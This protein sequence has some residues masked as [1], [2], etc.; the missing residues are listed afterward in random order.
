MNWNKAIRTSHRW[1]S[2]G[3]TL[4]VA[5][6]FALLGAGQQPEQWVYYLP[7]P[8]LALMLVTGLYLFVL[9]YLSRRVGSGGI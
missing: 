2:I 3:F 7:L 6:I 1:L 5:G 9:P 8:F 4:V